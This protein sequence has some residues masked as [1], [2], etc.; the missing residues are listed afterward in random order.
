MENDQ[1]ENL[2]YPDLTDTP[3][4]REKILGYVDNLYTQYVAAKAYFKE[5]RLKEQYDECSDKVGVILKEKQRIDDGFWMGVKLQALPKPIKPEYIYGYSTAE[6][7]KRFKK[8]LDEIE[9]EI[10]DEKKEYQPEYEKIER[11]TKLN[12]V[13]KELFENKWVPVPLYTVVRTEDKETNTLKINNSL[14][15]GVLRIHVGKTDYPKPNSFLIIK[16]NHGDESFERV[17]ELKGEKDFEESWD[18]TIGKDWENLWT[19]PLDIELKRKCWYKLGGSVPKGKLLLYLKDFK[20][21]NKMTGEYKLKPEKKKN[22]APFIKMT[23]SIRRPLGDAQFNITRRDEVN[24]TKQ[25]S[26]F[27]VTPLP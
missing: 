15:D 16:L 5:Q 1:Y 7:T 9:K 4:D 18:W 20:Y 12:D 17:V 10:S 14:P 11:L 26:P 19:K 25:Y 27:I 21:A 13:I 3:D 24:I 2:T 8:L 22:E 6:R 23:M